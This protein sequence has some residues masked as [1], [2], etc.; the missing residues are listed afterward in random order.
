MRRMTLF[1]SVLLLLSA[2][3]LAAPQGV[4]APRPHS[5]LLIGDSLS[6]GL[7]KQLERLFDGRKDV[8]F[9]RRGKVSSGLARPDFFD[10]EQ[11]LEDLAKTQRPDVVIIMIGANDNK[12]L[13]GDDGK[14][15]YFDDPA[16][17]ALYAEKASRLLSICRA[18]NP[19]VRIYWVGAPI[20]GD[21]ALSGDLQRINGVLKT[22]CEREKDCQ[23]VD[24]WQ[25]LADEQGGYAMYGKNASGDLA[26]LR[27]EDGVHVTAA[28]ARILAKDCISA[29]A[30]DL[31]L[32]SGE[33]LADAACLA[34]ASKDDVAKAMAAL[35][36]QESES[37]RLTDG[38]PYK[39]RQG[40]SLW[41]IARRRGL[42]MDRLLAYNPALDPDDVRPGQTI[43][44]PPAKARLAGVSA[45]EG[46]K[47]RIADAK[48]AAAS[49]RH[50]K[51]VIR[52]GDT[53]WS[54]AENFKVSPARIAKANPG[55]NPKA[56]RLGMTLDIPAP[57]PEKPVVAAGNN[58]DAAGLDPFIAARIAP[59]AASADVAANA[60]PDA[61]AAS[62]APDAAAASSAPDAIAADSAPDAAAAAA[63]AAANPALGV[64]ASSASAPHSGSDSAKTGAGTYVVADGDNYWSIAQRLG[65]GTAALKKANP[66][67][68]PKRL[69]PGQIL[70][71]PAS[72]A[73]AQAARSGGSGAAG[74]AQQAQA[75]PA[76][77]ASAGGASTETYLVCD[78]DNLW[79]IAKRFGVSVNELRKANQ[80]V[81]PK[82]LK[83]GQTLAIPERK[84]EVTGIKNGKTGDLSLDE[85]S[86]P[87][88][89]V[90]H[91][92]I[93]GD[94]F[95]ILSRRYNAD[96]ASIVAANA[97][98]DPRRLRVGENMA[99][100]LDAFASPAPAGKETIQADAPSDKIAVVAEGDT[101]WDIAKKRGLPMPALLAVNPGVDPVRLAIG[102]RINLPTEND[103]AAYEEHR[104]REA[105][106][107]GESDSIQTYV[108]EYGD[109]LW[110]LAQRFGVTV[111]LLARENGMA[112]PASLQ[113]GQALRIP[114]RTITLLDHGYRDL[115][116]H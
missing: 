4:S 55:V 71:L 58:E 109:N 79:G 50:D 78:G 92:I 20:M 77:T 114:A 22:L 57:A 104:F 29:V 12:A 48:A 82:K 70:A 86:A 9:S 67:V 5:V 97:G 73:S 43:V 75:D 110:T 76:A 7:G 98:L 103:L 31:G 26:P 17:D 36:T 14:A 68:N 95:W 90:A 46:I 72:G 66:G 84:S 49:M 25:S 113:A 115:A 34:P 10:W 85:P 116:A 44:L 13:T 8:V 27:V 107:G 1:L 69:R 30:P 108:A 64:T 96:L 111:E 16:W 42:E 81:N 52:Q 51:Y 112:D 61:L 94:T 89:A 28:G 40:E 102:Q 37:A 23:W 88:A 83:P 47:S 3:A 21:P 74:T 56:L 106:A 32:E 41:R 60:V 53:F 33:L 24:T 35:E 19:G 18:Y 100:P 105:L 87:Y 63:I 45:R 65:L 62:S 101:L 99:I 91:R 15:V 11:N 93:P 54:I 59:S 6:I 39:V 38:K 2:A 80:G